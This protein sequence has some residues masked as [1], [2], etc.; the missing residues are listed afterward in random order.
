ML[1]FQNMHLYRL[2]EVPHVYM[3][4]KIFGTKI[5]ISFHYIFCELI[6]TPS[7]IY[8]EHMKIISYL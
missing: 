4:F 8:D 5:N 3:D 7:Y 1:F 6:E 2:F